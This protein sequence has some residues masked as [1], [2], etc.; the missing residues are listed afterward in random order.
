MLWTVESSQN[1][2]KANI[3]GLIASVRIPIYTTAAMTAV[4]SRAFDEGWESTFQVYVKAADFLYDRLAASAAMA[5]IMMAFPAE[6]PGLLADTLLLGLETHGL[7]EWRTIVVTLFAKFE[8][9]VRSIDP[10]TRQ[11]TVRFTLALT[12]IT[13]YFVAFMAFIWALSQGMQLEV[14]HF[15]LLADSLMLRDNRFVEVET[16]TETHQGVPTSQFN[17]GQL[18]MVAMVVKRNLEVCFAT[19]MAR[20][21]YGIEA[22]GCRPSKMGVA[23]PVDLNSEMAKLV[24]DGSLK[25]SIVPIDRHAALVLVPFFTHENP[26]LRFLIYQKDESVTEAIE[27]SH[28]FENMFRTFYPHYVAFDA[29]F[30]FRL[31][32]EGKPYLVVYMRVK[33]LC[34][35]AD[36]VPMETLVRFHERL[37]SMLLLKCKESEH[38]PSVRRYGDTFVFPIDAVTVNRIS[39]WK[40]LETGTEFGGQ[41]MGIVRELQVEFNCDLSPFILIFRTVGPDVYA[42]HR[43]MAIAD[44]AGDV[45]WAGE[46]RTRSCVGGSIQFASMRRE[47]KIP[48]TTKLKMA[49]T[50][51]GEKFDLF[52]IV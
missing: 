20:M 49:S 16:E 37:S 24:E 9:M 46:E 30:P 5:E 32:S 31:K 40:V 2:L 50:A 21:E 34:E 33:R 8:F 17:D 12:L 4:R 52:V 35:W 47:S 29:P 23:L 48:N 28:G 42:T 26:E 38:F 22:I 27:I 44:A 45:L 1:D 7:A 43:R 51:S 39:V 41:L 14:T 6:L 19:D 13:I 3:S 15:G 18:T 10:T 11:H 25:Q 36:Q